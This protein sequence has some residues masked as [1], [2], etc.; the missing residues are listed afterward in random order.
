MSQKTGD[1]SEILAQ[2]RT[3]IVAH[4]FL[5]W[6]SAAVAG[7]AFLLGCR[8]GF[9]WDHI[10]A[11]TDLTA[12]APGG[13][14]DGTTYRRHGRRL[15]LA[16]W[17]CIGHGSVIVIFGIAIG[18]LGLHLPGAIDRV[19][20]S[21]VGATLVALGA[22]VLWQLGRDKSTYRYS[23]RIRLLIGVVRRAWARARRRGSGPAEALDDL[24]P[25]SAFAV[26]VLHGTGA[27]TPTQVLL[28]AGAATSGSKASAVLLMVSFVCGM[29]LAD[30]GIAASWLAGLLG[31][32]SAPK[33]QIFLGGLT[34]LSSLAVGGLFLVGRSAFLPAL[35]G[36]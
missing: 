3:V 2:G 31:V 22:F 29:V 36:G 7:T 33:A 18:V 17:Y 26:G 24:S 19:F 8:H 11:I 32:R 6:S 30:V 28:F 1:G 14:L 9:D 13:P 20:E 35:F 5:S 27:E 34:G 25:R 12:A 21:V 23:G 4:P 16:F 15:G 10:S